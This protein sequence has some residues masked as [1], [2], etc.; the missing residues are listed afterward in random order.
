[1]AYELV[2]AFTW[3]LIAGLIGLIT[4][5]VFSGRMKMPRNRFLVPYVIFASIFL[6]G[7]FYF[8][9][10]DLIDLLLQNWFY[11]VIAGVIVGAILTRNVM[12]Q[13]SSSSPSDR[14]LV[15]DILWL[16]IIYGLIDSLLLN[17][18]PVIAVWNAF[19]QIGLL[20]TWTWQLLAG[21]L[22]L[23]ASLLVTLLYHLG[24]TEFRNK[25]VGFVLIGNTI[26]TLAYL[27][28]TNPFGAILSHIIMHIAAVIRGPETTIQL[29]PHYF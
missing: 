12:S 25:K 13:S 26:I 17:V 4:S 8:D 20:S 19:S 1:M 28:S 27:L 9:S 24:Y 5:A 21:V 10:I 7:F 11:G 15:M 14:N 3:V 18:M 6:L 22:G 2:F 23:G 29:P 16:G